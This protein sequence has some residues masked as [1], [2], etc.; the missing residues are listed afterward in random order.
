MA[1]VHAKTRQSG[2]QCVILYTQCSVQKSVNKVVF[3]YFKLSTGLKN[4]TLWDIAYTDLY[5]HHN[6]NVTHK[7]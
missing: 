5:H 7:R 2:N 6:T 3:W 4:I 1:S